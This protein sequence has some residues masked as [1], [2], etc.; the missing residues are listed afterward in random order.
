MYQGIYS[1][2]K[3]T[4]QSECQIQRNKPDP[5]STFNVSMGFSYPEG[6]V[7][8][9]KLKPDLPSSVLGWLYC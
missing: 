4:N 5:Q 6:F 9:A 8:I 1:N 7:K 2:S 3:V